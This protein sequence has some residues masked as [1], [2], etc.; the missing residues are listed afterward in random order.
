M[1]RRNRTI[2]E[3]AAELIALFPN[4]AKSG[5]VNL[6]LPPLEQQH[7]VRVFNAIG[8]LVWS[9]NIGSQQPLLPMDLTGLRSGM[10]VVR[11]SGPAVQYTEKLILK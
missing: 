9:R 10:Y 8:E 11:V 2:N 4:P 7:E 6:S 3:E 1:G 5:L